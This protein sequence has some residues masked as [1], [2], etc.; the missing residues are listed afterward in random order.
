MI[1]QRLGVLTTD[2]YINIAIDLF[3]PV[4]NSFIPCK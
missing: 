4:G 2:E 3:R 1:F